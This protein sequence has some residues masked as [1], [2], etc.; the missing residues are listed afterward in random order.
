LFGG[1]ASSKLAVAIHLDGFTDGSSPDTT[2]PIARAHFQLP[3]GCFFRLEA[4]FHE[5]ASLHRLAT[6]LW[7]LSTKAWY[8]M[9]AS[10]INPIAVN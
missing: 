4:P 5:R 10:E 3:S 1:V 2:P 6:N 8:K 7:V 9:I